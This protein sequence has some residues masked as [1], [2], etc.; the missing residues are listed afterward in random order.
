VS[1]SPAG[2][3]IVLAG[4]DG[5]TKLFPVLNLDQLLANG[6]AQLNPFLIAYPDRLAAAPNLVRE[7]AT[8]AKA[9]NIDVAIDNFRAP[10]Q[11]NP[12]P[13]FNPEARAIQ[14]VLE[15]EAER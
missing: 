12:S 1:F 2:K 13:N 3:H 6:C 5:T 7:A 11:W 4:E 9:G 10:L 8:Q 14:S 15:G